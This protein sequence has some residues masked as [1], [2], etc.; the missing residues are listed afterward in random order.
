VNSYLVTEHRGEIFIICYTKISQLLNSKN[1][2]SN[3][4]VYDN[5]IK[6]TYTH[7]SFV[8]MDLNSFQVHFSLIMYGK[9]MVRSL[10]FFFRV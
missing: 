7:I 3:L 1:D 9:N 2:Y 4:Y 8:H 6:S 10:Y 5:Q